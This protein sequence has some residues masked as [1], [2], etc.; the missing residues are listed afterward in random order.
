MA[1]QVAKACGAYVIIAGISKDMPRLELAK[2]LGIDRAVNVQEEDL[3]SIVNDITNGYGVDVVLECSG[4]IPAV[5]SAVDLL[6]KKGILVQVG[7]F[8]KSKN[9][10]DYEN[11]VQKEI[12]Y[13]G[14]RSQKPSSWDIAL[15][16][17]A[18]KKV[19]LKSLVSHIYKLDQWEEAFDKVMKGEGIKIVLES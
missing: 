1:A 9:E 2:K 13:I 18:K 8:A 5:D 15:N 7:I 16:L 4:A 3:K 11:L 19:D 14:C 6:R 17:M 10:F 12:V